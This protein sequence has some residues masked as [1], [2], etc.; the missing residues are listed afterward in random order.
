MKIGIMQPYFMPYIGYFQL[1]NAVDK[2]VIYDEIEF[3][4]RGWIHRN[5]FLMN[6]KPTYFTIGLKKASDYLPV[7]QRELS[8]QYLTKDRRK[9]LAQLQNNYRKAPQF[10]S[11]FPIIQ[12]C[13]NHPS[14]NLFEYIFNAIKQICVYIGVT[15]PLIVS[16]TVTAADASLKNKERVIDLVKCLEGDTYIN[17][18]GGVD[19]YDKA[20]FA[21]EGID[22]QFMKANNVEYP[23][24]KHEFQPF[25]S[26][27]DVLMFN[28]VEEVQNLLQEYTVIG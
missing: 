12:A 10:N 18:S 19:L 6:G 2:F 16:S 3:S 14:T 25:L 7:V 22:L 11:V 4:K 23:Q 17:P 20:E 26:I 28:S 5:R 1:I 8:E 24:F 9:I 27:V 13:L 15:T 21:N